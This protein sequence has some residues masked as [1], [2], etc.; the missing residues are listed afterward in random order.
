MNTEE[1]IVTW[2]I[3]LGA[4]N[5]PKMMIGD[6]VQFLKTSLRDGVVL[7]KLLLRLL[8]GSIEKVRKGLECC[9]SALW[10]QISAIHREAGIAWR[11]KEAI[12]K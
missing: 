1:Q 4:L 2:L 5:S 8:P 9:V 11:P 6:P 12:P 3:S 7:C 10:V